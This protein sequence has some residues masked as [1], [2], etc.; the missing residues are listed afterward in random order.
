MRGRFLLFLLGVT[1]RCLSPSLWS[2]ASSNLAQI[3]AGVRPV[4]HNQ[5]KCHQA[6]T[7]SQPGRGHENI[8]RSSSLINVSRFANLD[9]VKKFARHKRNLRV[10]LGVRTFVV[11]PASP[12]EADATRLYPLRRVSPLPPLAFGRAIGNSRPGIHLFVGLIGVKPPESWG[13]IHRFND[14]ASTFLP[15]FYLRADSACR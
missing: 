4:G 6:R 8:R 11:R 10:G 5:P 12:G 2:V 1:R 14:D 13:R 15:H 9:Q 7:Q 3:R